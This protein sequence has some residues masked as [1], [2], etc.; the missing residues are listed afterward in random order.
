MSDN[1]TEQTRATGARYMEF[2]KLLQSDGFDREAA[3]TDGTFGKFLADDFMWYMFTDTLMEEKT[4]E[5]GG[6]VAPAVLTRDEILAFL[7]KTKRIFLKPSTFEI[8]R[9]LADG[10]WGIAEFRRS[11]RWID[12]SPYVGDYVMVFRVRGDQFTE[13][14]EY[15]VLLPVGSARRPAEKK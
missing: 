6:E 12:G 15:T 1:T 14:N 5:L 2:I 4:R 8:H 11:A 3:F 9:I 7:P 10:E 13:I